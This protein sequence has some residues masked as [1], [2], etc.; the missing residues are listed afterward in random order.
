MICPKCG[1]VIQEGYM[2][3]PT[4]GEEVIMVPDF[5]V[6]L[7]AG[8][9]QTISEVAEMMAD[10]VEGDND[11]KAV[12]TD[13][14]R[15]KSPKNNKANVKLKILIAAAAVLGLVFVIGIALIVKSVRSYYSFDKQFSKL[16]EEFGSGDHEAAI[17]TAKHV[18]SINPDDER[19]RLMLA[20]SYFTLKKY[21]ESIAVLDG[22]LNDF[23]KDI[24]IYERLIANYEA[25]GDVDS[26]ISLSERADPTISNS[27]FQDYACENPEFSEEAGNYYGKQTIKL[28]VSGKGTIYYTLDGSYPDEDANVYTQPIVLDE[29][30]TTIRAVHVNDKGVKSEE[31]SKTYNIIIVAPATP[32]LLTQAGDYSIPK[33]I[34]LEE[35]QA[36]TL[37]YTTD[38]TD[39]TEDSKVYEP[40]I[41]MP[42]GKSEF[43]FAIIN[44]SGESSEVTVA[45]YNLSISGIDKEY[46]AG[47]VQLTL[48][49]LGHDVSTHEF[50]AKYGY[51]QGASSYYVIEEYAGSQ[52][53]NTVYAVDAQNGGVFTI[54]ANKETGDY[55]FGVVQ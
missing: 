32:K 5:E 48:I 15:N 52:K 50:K 35:P 33:L 4:C 38:G 22:L 7:E 37:Y 10:S 46:A 20:D 8:I 44:D 25:E 19:A 1:T 36:G 43:R 6:E 13:K 3:C 24:S 2:Y 18:I 49:S 16:E 27:L 31:V 40:P 53:Q 45:E 39:P 41:L 29:G 17:K 51:A 21:D 26:I 11:G 14:K 47:L 34:K 12:S 23:P 54:T 42:L 28:T 55:D 9:E 30:E